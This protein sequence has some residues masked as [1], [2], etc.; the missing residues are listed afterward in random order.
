MTTAKSVLIT[1]ATRGLGENLARQ[2]RAVEI[3][4]AYVAVC[5]QRYADHTGLSPELI[6]D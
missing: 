6:E 3:S 4:P 5:L 2:C 1:G